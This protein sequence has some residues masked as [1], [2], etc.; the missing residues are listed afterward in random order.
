LSFNDNVLDRKRNNYLACVHA[1]PE[2]LFGIAFLDLSTGE[3]M[4][5]QGNAEYAGK[6]LQGFRP[7]EMVYC[8]RQKDKISGFRSDNISEFTLDEWVYGY[9][10]AE[11][12]LCNQFQTN[13]LKGF[14]IHHM[15]L[16]IIAA[17]AAL[18]YLDETEHRETAHI[19][20]ISRLDEKQHVWLDRFTIRNLELIHPQQEGGVPLIQILDHT[21]T[22]MGARLLRKWIVLPLKSRDAINHRHNVIEA[23]IGAKP[24]MQKIGESMRRIG[25]LERLIGKV[26]TRRIN[27]RELAQLRKSIG[28]LEPV[29]RL[30]EESNDPFLQEISSK[31]DPCDELSE[32][33]ARE[34][35]DDPP[36]V[37]HQGGIINDGIDSA[38]DELR[39]IA[40]SGKDYLVQIQKR[41]C[42]RTGIPSLKIA[43]NKVFGYYLEVS[44]T[45]RN[46]V[47]EEWIRK[48]TLVNAERY[49]TEELKIYE[50]KI[51]NAEEKLVSV[52][53]RLFAKL[54]EYTAG[55]TQLI[56]ENARA[57]ASLDCLLS[58]ATVSE[59]FRYCRPEVDD[60]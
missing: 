44:N 13:S 19:S 36:V 43:Y 42:E 49:I 40:F 45:H 38:L 52:E 46:K 31:I 5:A 7:A 29:K 34:L 48:Q 10:Y 1:G 16:A 32:R 22:P 53:Q 39:Q 35:K 57:I 12:K 24:V 47:P 2:D 4:A 27:P 50:E 30:L 33:L 8:K 20:S 28:I 9:D 17:G 6:L 54:V 25:D 51:L 58:F 3:F 21:C 15:P 11:E 26:A 37:T 41:E 23:L 55:F 18:H 56:Q 59:R 60:S 14:G